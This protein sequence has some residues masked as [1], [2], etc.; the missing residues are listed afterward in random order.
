MDILLCAGDEKRRIMQVELGYNGVAII[1]NELQQINYPSGVSGIESLYVLRQSVYL[2][3]TG[4]AG[5]LYCCNLA[6]LNVELLLR[7]SPDS[8]N[9]IKKLCGYGDSIVFTDSSDR[10]VKAFDPLSTTV[11]TLMGT[12]HEGTADGTDENC[13][14]TQ[15]HG[16]CFL[17]NTI[18]VSNIDA[19][20]IKLVLGLTGTV[21]FLHNLGCRYDSF[22]INAQTIN[23]VQL[24][25]QDVETNVSSV[26][27]YIKTEVKQHY[28]M[29]KA[30]TNGPDGTVPRKTQVSRGTPRERD[31]TT[32][33]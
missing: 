9:E 30:A 16:I 25:L 32:T 1:G 3:V 15:V 26:N 18:F 6:T 7:N 31:E 23:A 11:K 12:G 13:I 8:C 29:K 22:G 4:T 20:T 5:S 24:S 14:F 19:G 10:K 28:N 21:S 33:R 2:A 17:Q 27:E